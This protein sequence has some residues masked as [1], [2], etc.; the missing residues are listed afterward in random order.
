MRAGDVALTTDP[1]ASSTSDATPMSWSST[2]EPSPLSAW[3][4]PTIDANFDSCANNAIDPSL[5]LA[6]PISA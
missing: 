1:T 6:D 3:S 4:P 5:L 2:D